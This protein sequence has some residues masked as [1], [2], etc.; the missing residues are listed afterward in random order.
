M[1]INEVS[2]VMPVHNEEDILEQ[3]V[4]RLIRFLDANGIGFELILCENGS[5]DAT[6]PICRKLR[7]GSSRIKLIEVPFAS[8][9][10]ALRRGF[11][12]ARMGAILFYPADLSHDVRF[13]AQALPLLDRHDAVVASR[14][15]GAMARRPL[16]RIMT[17]IHPHVINRLFG[18]HVTDIGSLKIYRREMGQRVLALT[19]SHGSFVEVETAVLL[20]RLGASCAEIP[21]IHNETRKSRWAIGRMLFQHAADLVREYARL[22]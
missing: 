4:P 21:I 6:L 18:T 1:P 12:E 15:M 8:L 11:R 19:R 10:E 3:N 13:I 17:K 7:G 2:V 22:K 9:G 20:H 5:S 14:N 16:R